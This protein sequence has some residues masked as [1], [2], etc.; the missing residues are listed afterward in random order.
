MALWSFLG[1]NGIS[2]IL[3]FIAKLIMFQRTHSKRWALPSDG[4]PSALSV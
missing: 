1:F 3:M 2:N 4:K